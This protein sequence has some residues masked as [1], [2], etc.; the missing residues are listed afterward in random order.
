[1]EN[2]PDEIEGITLEDVPVL[3]LVPLPV[4]LPVVACQ[5]PDGVQYWYNE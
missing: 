3:I 5:N 4:P 2:I 1:M